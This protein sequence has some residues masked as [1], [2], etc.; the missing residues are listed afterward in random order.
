M[1]QRRLCSAILFLE[2][3][4]LGLSAAVLRSVEGV[5]VAGALSIGL[6]L[7]LACLVV[8]GLLR[9]GWAYYL[10]WAIQVAA[11]ALGVE[12][13][14]MFVLGAIFLLLWLTAVR[15]GGTIDRDKAAAGVGSDQ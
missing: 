7:A 1:M 4:V 5:S 12:V 15:L 8:A 2:A 10:G 14:A 9:F 11:I 13:T 6:G 3:I